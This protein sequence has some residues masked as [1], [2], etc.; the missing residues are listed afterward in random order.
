MERLENNDVNQSIE[1]CT[2]AFSYYRFAWQKMWK[3]FLE[4]LLITIISFLVSIPTWGL[5]DNETNL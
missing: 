5:W 2:G 3:Y 1:N 4:L